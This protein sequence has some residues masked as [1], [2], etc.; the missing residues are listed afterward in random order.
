MRRAINKRSQE[1]ESR[2]LEDVGYGALTP[3][4]G[5]ERLLQTFKT[6]DL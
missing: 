6:A 1:L 5:G 2:S 3:G 4:S